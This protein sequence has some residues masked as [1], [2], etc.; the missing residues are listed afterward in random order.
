MFDFSDING[1]HVVTDFAAFAQAD[2]WLSGRMASS[3]SPMNFSKKPHEHLRY[4]GS[5]NPDIA[6][7]IRASL[8][9]QYLCVVSAQKLGG[10]REKFIGSL[11]VCQMPGTDLL[12][13]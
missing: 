1:R 5:T 6:S 4:A 2:G 7:A 9:P 11:E 3:S 8:A 12:A 13:R 10:Q